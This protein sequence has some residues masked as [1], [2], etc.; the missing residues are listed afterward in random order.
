M[1]Q[2]DEDASGGRVGIKVAHIDTFSAPR[3]SAHIRH[4][5]FPSHKLEI[6]GPSRM[7]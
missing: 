7:A 6:L 5:L 3:R 4:T 2:G 1:D